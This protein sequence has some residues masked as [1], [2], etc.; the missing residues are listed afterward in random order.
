M[1]WLFPFLWQ[2]VTKYL[3]QLSSSTMGMEKEQRFHFVLKAGPVGQRNFKNIMVMSGKLQSKDTWQNGQ[4]QNLQSWLKCHALTTLPPALR[5]KGFNL[6]LSAQIVICWGFLGCGK[7]FQGQRGSRLDNAVQ[8]CFPE[9]SQGQFWASPKCLGG[10]NNF[11][12][13]CRKG[14]LK[15]WYLGNCFPLPHSLP[16]R[17]LGSQLCKY[18]QIY[19]GVSENRHKKSNH[20]DSLAENK[21]LRFI[22]LSRR[23]NENYFPCNM[24]DLAVFPCQSAKI[25]NGPCPKLYHL[26]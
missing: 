22:L 9:V 11:C 6:F 3:S 16:K 14:S 19:R 15:M 26:T 25:C 12:E 10:A 7:G 8:E 20:C 21:E 2:L 23:E 5:V 4:R 17:E 18:L 13:P 1:P 24:R